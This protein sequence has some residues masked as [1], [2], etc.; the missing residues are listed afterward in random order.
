MFENQTF[1]SVNLCFAAYQPCGCGQVT[2]LSVLTVVLD[3]FEGSECHY[4][5]DILSLMF[6]AYCAQ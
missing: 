5:Q 1:W 3:C 4:V 6:G 2:A